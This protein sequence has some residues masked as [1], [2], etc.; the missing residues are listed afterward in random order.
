MNDLIESDQTPLDGGGSPLPDAST[1]EEGEISESDEELDADFIRNAHTMITTEL[2]REPPRVA[3]A[4]LTFI[5]PEARVSIEPEEDPR[6]RATRPLD[7]YE[8]FLGTAD[9]P[10]I[11]DLGNEARQAAADLL[12]NSLGLTEEGSALHGTIKLALGFHE[13]WLKQ[14]KKSIIATVSASAYA[15]N[16]RVT[17]ALL[18]RL[19]V[20]SISDGDEDNDTP[21][22]TARKD[23]IRRR[24]TRRLIEKKKIDSEAK[25]SVTAPAEPLPA[26]RRL[27]NHHDFL[28]VQ[29]FLMDL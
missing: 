28:A 23:I 29:I 8:Q 2:D 19:N 5:L 6:P 26:N 20:A 10:A 12:R 11:F 15:W 17:D 18:R 21:E 3:P 16:A 7:K 1:R 14:N 4:R 24:K 27:A 9:P 13:A 25:D 22:I